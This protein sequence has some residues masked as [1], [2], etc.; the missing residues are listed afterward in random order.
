MAREVKTKRL[1]RV[2]NAWDGPP[3]DLNALFPGE[4]L[5][6]PK[7]RDFIEYLKEQLK[8]PAQV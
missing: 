2:L 6:S 4:R 7:V 3:H 1:R 5:P 8:F